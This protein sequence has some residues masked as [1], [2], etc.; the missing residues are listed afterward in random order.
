MTYGDII[1][2]GL[3]LCVVYLLLDRGVLDGGSDR[4][5]RDVDREKSMG[6][7]RSEFRILRRLRDEERDSGREDERD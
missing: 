7:T 5:D 2:A 1:V 6:D 3:I 4:R